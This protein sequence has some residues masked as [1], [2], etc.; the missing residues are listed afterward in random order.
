MYFGDY[1]SVPFLC[2]TI[3]NS[4][5]YYQFINMSHTFTKITTQVAAFDY[6]WSNLFSKTH[7]LVARCG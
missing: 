5:L 2:Y 7:I 1:L 4:V 6:L 3:N